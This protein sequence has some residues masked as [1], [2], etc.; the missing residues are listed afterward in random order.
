VSTAASGLASCV[1]ATDSVAEAAPVAVG[2]NVT[3]MVQFAPAAKVVPQVPPAVPAGCTNTPAAVG[4]VGVSVMLTAVSGTVPGLDSVSVCAVLVVVSVWGAKAVGVDSVGGRTRPVMAA[5]S[6]DA[7]LMTCRLVVRVP[8]AVGVNVTLIVQ[9]ALAAKLAPQVLVCAKSV[10]FPVV[11][12]MLVISSE[13]LVDVLV[14][15]TGCEAV[16]VPAV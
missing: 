8:M 7:E 11:S 2:P 1:A 14:S 12:P 13:P 4:A 15:V 16:A 9:L 3:L 6:V 10:V 5:F